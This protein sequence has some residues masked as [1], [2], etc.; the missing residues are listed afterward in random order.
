MS[1]ELEAAEQ[2]QYRE[3]GFFVRRALFGAA[4]L[5]ALRAGAEAVHARVVAAA[6]GR[7][8]PSEWRVDDRRYQQL[9]GATVKWE[10]GEGA[11][12]IRS[13]EPCAHLDPR[14]EALLGDRRLTRPIA[15]LLG[16]ARLSLFTDKLNFKRP[17]GSPFPWHQDTPYWAFGCAHLERLASVQLYLDDATREAGCLWAIAG[18]HRRGV[19]PAVRDRG[20]LGR[21]YTDVDQL[22]GERVALEAPAG[23]A[24][25][26]D[27]A[28]VHGSRGNRGAAA[29]RALVLTYQPPGL[30]RWGRSDVRDVG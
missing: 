28:L 2:R 4:E 11:Q 27:G 17:G 5:E 14:L 21:L 13:L 29:R 3:R 15:G 18:S 26:F 30:P 19:L 6:A 16:E 12:P 25:F 8:A 10:W 20:V 1:W 22:E 23:S 24:V 9:L 7:G